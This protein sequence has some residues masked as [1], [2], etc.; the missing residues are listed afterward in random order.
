MINRIRTNFPHRYLINFGVFQMATATMTSFGTTPA[1]KGVTG[2]VRFFQ[3]PFIA[4]DNSRFTI[5]IV[6]LPVDTD[7]WVC[8]LK[9]HDGTNDHDDDI[10]AD[11]AV[12]GTGPVVNIST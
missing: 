4:S 12:T 5:E 11:E 10:G 6:G 1:H 3:N 7:Y 8:L 2:T 9:E